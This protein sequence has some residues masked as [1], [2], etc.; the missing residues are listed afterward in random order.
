M[1]PV[2][3]PNN[4]LSRNLSAAT[5]IRS[6]GPYFFGFGSFGGGDSAGSCGG[7]GCAAGSCGYS[8]CGGEYSSD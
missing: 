7:A 6:G 1:E 4:L 8:G 2:A 5:P 3:D